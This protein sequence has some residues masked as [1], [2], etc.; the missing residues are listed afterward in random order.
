MKKKSHAQI[1]P[2]KNQAVKELEQATMLNEVALS[3]GVKMLT[4]IYPNDK[5]LGAAVRKGIIEGMDI[6]KI[7]EQ[8]DSII[9]Q[10]ETP[11]TK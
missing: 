8:L 5:E 2:Q 6:A 1:K 7:K 11:K 4:Q 9:N 3:L 10:E